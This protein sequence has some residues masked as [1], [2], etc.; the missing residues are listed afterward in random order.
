MHPVSR[1][2]AP[3]GGDSAVLT[4]LAPPLKAPLGLRAFLILLFS[5]SSRS[6]PSLPP[7]PRSCC[8]LVLAN[9]SCFQALRGYEYLTRFS[10]KLSSAILYYFVLHL[11]T[12][13][14]FFFYPFAIVMSLNYFRTFLFLP[15]FLCS[16]CCCYCFSPFSPSYHS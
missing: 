1:L 3:Q 13:T 12:F 15:F 10:F 2:E 7:L 9:A 8:R 11:Y 6:L 4:N 14:C 5:S 16:C